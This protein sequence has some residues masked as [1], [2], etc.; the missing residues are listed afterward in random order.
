MKPIPLILAGVAAIILA[1]LL[2]LPFADTS[3][4]PPPGSLPWQI[5]VHEDGATEVFGFV[6]GRSTLGEAQT[7]FGKDLE[8]AVV[9]PSGGRGSLEAFNG[10]ARAGFITGKLVLT[11][12]LPQERVD[13]MRE[14]AVRSAYM[15]SSTRKATLHADDLAAALD[16]PIGA[17]TFIP[18]ADLDEEVILARFGRPAERLASADHLQHFLYP[19]HGLEVTLDSRGKEILQYVA[20]RDFERLRAPLL[21]AA[22]APAAEAQ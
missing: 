7:R 12:D 22:D 6:L 16:A 20:P 9:T 11:A 17:I 21:E 3:E 19:E 2:Y 8:I 5:E 18:T 13:A 10:D 4:A 14:R 15:D 1:P